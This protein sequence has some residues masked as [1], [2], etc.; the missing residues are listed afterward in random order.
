MRQKTRYVVGDNDDITAYLLRPVEIDRPAP[1]ILAM[2]QTVACGKDEVAGVGGC[3]DYAY[4]HELAMHGCIIL[5]PDF[6]TVGT[7]SYLLWQLT[8]A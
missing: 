8:S 3:S 2:H 5:I 1:A 4:G 6:L 7:M